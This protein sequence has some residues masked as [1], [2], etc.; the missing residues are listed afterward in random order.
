VNVV[1]LILQP[2]LAVTGGW[3][4]F[5]ASSMPGASDDSLHAFYALIVMAL[6]YYLVTFLLSRF[7]YARIRDLNNP[8]KYLITIVI[9]FILMTAPLVPAYIAY[10]LLVKYNVF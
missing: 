4:I 5:R 9:Q 8:R 2:V 3:Y 1:L 10:A 7:L 6:M